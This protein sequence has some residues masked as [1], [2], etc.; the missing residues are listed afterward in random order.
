MPTIEAHGVAAAPPKGWDAQIYVR[1]DVAG[2]PS[3]AAGSASLAPEDVRREVARPVAHLAN[4]PL[5]PGR[6]DMGGG[7]VEVMGS[8]GIFV[9]LVEFD[10]SEAGVGVFAQDGPP[11]P[12]TPDDFG[13][14]FLQRSFGGQSG[15]QRFFTVNG[16]P[17][18]LYVVLGSH[19]QRAVLVPALNDALAAVSFA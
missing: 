12:L 8:G 3:G 17:F 5:P 11:W 7:A 1:D 4:F 19:A 18:S 9:A 15:C 10:P 13:P 14:E 6:A 16:R 2:P